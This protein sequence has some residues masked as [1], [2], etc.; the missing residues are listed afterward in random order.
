MS[1]KFKSEEVIANLYYKDLFKKFTDLNNLK[2]YLPKEVKEF[3]SSTE[4]CSFKIEQLPKISLQL[5]EK[6]AYSQIKFES[7]ESQIPF[8]MNCYLKKIDNNTTNVILEINMEVNFMMKMLVQK[9]INIFLE[10]FTEIIKK[11]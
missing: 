9:P 6:I 11:I 1:T 7:N 3:E 4:N 10:N 5:T 8:E 2:G